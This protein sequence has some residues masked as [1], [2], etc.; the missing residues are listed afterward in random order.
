[1]SRRIPSGNRSRTGAILVLIVVLIPVLLMLSAFAINI[2]YMELNRTE[3]HT[4][5]DAAARAAGREF[6]VTGSIAAAKTRAKQFAEL[7]EIAGNPLTL[8]DSDIV[9]GVSQRAS[10]AVRYT[11]TPGGTNPNAIRVTARRTAAAPDGAVPLLMPNV[12]G[13]GT[14]NINH[15]AV[16]SLVEMDI[17]LVIDRSG[18]MAY[19]ANEVAAFPPAPASAPAGW[20]FCDAAPPNSR[21][22]NVVD[23]T[24]VFLAQLNASPISEL[25]SLSTYNHGAITDQPLTGNYALITASLNNY[26]NS[27][28]SGGTNIGGGIN[29]GSGA[30]ASSPAAREGAVKVIIVLTDG[31]HNIGTNPISAATSAAS[32]GV[33]IFT[34]TFSAEANQ[35]TMQSVAAVGNGRH[36]H[37]NSPSDLI[38]VFQAITKLLPNLL[39]K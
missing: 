39:T 29:E 16:S 28:C 13:I 10:T 11:F 17:A 14:F 31:I 19:A 6:T 22:R 4:A 7:N 1:M 12:F 20:T 30:L 8:A 18:S 23:A 9:A 26:T 25:V 2:A 32:G 33:L 15:E 27:L 38:Q 24:S 3:A 21:W 35:S 36:F 34:I 5:A 37:A